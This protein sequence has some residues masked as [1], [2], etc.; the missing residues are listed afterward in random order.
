MN[1][2]LFLVTV[3]FSIVKSLWGQGITLN[4]N[5]ERNFVFEVKQIDEFFERFNNE[6]N[7]LFYRYV[8]TKFPGITIDRIS[9]VNNLFN[10]ENKH[11]DS[12]EVKGFAS[13]VAD[14]I[15]PV[16]L[17]FASNEWYAATVCKF[18]YLGKNTDI[19]IILKIQQERNGG[20]KWMIVSAFC[21]LI[22]PESKPAHLHPARRTSKFLNPMSQATDF[23]NLAEAF[24]DEA[25]VR[26][27]LDSSFYQKPRSVAFLKALLRKQLEFSF[28]KRINYYFLQVDGWIFRVSYYQR[29]SSNSGWLISLLFR[30]SPEDKEKFKNRL[31]R[32][33]L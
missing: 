27:Y 2:Y 14:S 13:F 9:L 21:P 22:G 20:M 15:H 26:D 18:K 3:F 5:R 16:F 10:K 12:A 6:K 24:E 25:D 23:M 17:D 11:F 33:T 4:N 30:A 28:V 1:R 8:A 31:W 7:T 19:T 32:K 29:Q